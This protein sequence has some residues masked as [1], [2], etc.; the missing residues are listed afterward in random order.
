LKRDVADR[1][2]PMNVLYKF[3][4]L[5]CFLEAAVQ[6]GC[7]TIELWGGAPHVDIEGAAPS[8]VRRV[9]RQIEGRGLSVSCFTP[10]ISLYPVNIA[11]DEEH[12]RL[13]SESYVTKSLE[14]AV[15]LG[16]PV[17]QI[18]SGTGY[19]HMPPDEAWRRSAESL[20]RIARRAE[21]LG[22]Q[23][24]L[25]PLPQYESNLVC[26]VAGIE[27]MLDEIGSP[28]VGVL[29]DTVVAAAAGDDP[30]IYFRK[31]GKRVLHAQWIDGPEGHLAWG[32]GRLPLERFWNAVREADYSGSFGLELYD[33]KYYVEPGPVL[34]RCVETMR[35][36]E[37]FA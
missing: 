6:S 8:D 31:F 26:D 23:L 24:A 18:S 10:E 13:R 27:R 17:M 37:S 16:A 33:H 12:V 4:S 5:D 11:S 9:K 3:F 28:A 29:L 2:A 25:E 20:G 22:I 36:L 32:D 30:D 19:R 34:R 1:I 15:E 14:I 21:S 35:G 7:K